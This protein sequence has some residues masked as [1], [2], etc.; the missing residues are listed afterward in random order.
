MLSVVFYL[1]VFLFVYVIQS[2][3]ERMENG[4]RQKT[5]VLFSFAIMLLLIGLRYYVGTDY[6]GHIEMYNEYSNVSFDELMTLR[7]DIGSKII[8]GIIAPMF[9]GPLVLFWIYGVLALIPLLII[10]KKQKYKYLA[11]STL[12]YNLLILPVDLNIIRQGAAMSFVLLAFQL[13]DDKN[14]TRNK[15]KILLCMIIAFILHTSA[16]LMAPYLLIYLI[17]KKRKKSGLGA[18]S[19]VTAIFSIMAFTSLKGIFEDIGF[20]DYNYMLNV[21]SDINVSVNTVLLNILILLPVFLSEIM[22]KRGDKN[23]R[24]DNVAIIDKNIPLVLSGTVFEIIGTAFKYL[25]RISHYFAIFNIILIPRTIQK[26]QNRDLRT[27]VK[28]MCIIILVS[29]FIIRCY[30]QGRYGII[31]YDTWLFKGVY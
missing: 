28:A 5:L 30:Y 23:N 25:S 11:L 15:R 3:A 4:R 14:N 31:P 1:T 12:I 18:V 17:S 26:I 22:I 13:A 29:V 9:G 16:F 27:L 8:V 2:I 7:G 10:N 20:T 21:Q 6:A 24:K 19:I